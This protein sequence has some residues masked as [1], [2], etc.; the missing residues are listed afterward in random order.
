MCLHCSHVCLLRSAS[1]LSMGFVLVPLVRLRPQYT[2]G[3]G[4]FAKFDGIATVTNVTQYVVLVPGVSVVLWF[5]SSSFHSALPSH[6]VEHHAPWGS[7]KEKI[8]DGR[9][10]TVLRY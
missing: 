6:R 2:H 5:I 10:P 4:A 9:V 1:P 3:V 8:K 7:D